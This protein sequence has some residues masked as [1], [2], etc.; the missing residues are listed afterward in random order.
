MNKDNLNENQFLGEVLSQ[1]L[2]DLEGKVENKA[3]EY[4]PIP[5]GRIS[6]EDT[7]NYK[8]TFHDKDAI[9]QTQSE[10]FK[11]IEDGSLD[12]DEVLSIHEIS[13]IEVFKE[14]ILAQ[15]E[16]SKVSDDFQYFMDKYYEV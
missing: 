7:I 9:S 11:I 10:L 1:I 6:E 13:S 3:K 15:H 5:C 8:I 14:E 16:W 2:K 12:F 4:S